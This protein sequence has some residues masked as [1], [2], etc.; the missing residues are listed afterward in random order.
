MATGANTTVYFIKEVTPGVTPDTPKWTPVGYKS[1]SLKREQPLINSERMRGDRMNAPSVN[2]VPKV[3]G[4]ISTEL[5]YGE[6]DQL[7]AAAF[8]LADWNSEKVKVGK[9]NQTFSILEKMDGVTGKKWRIYRGCVVNT[10]SWN[11]EAGAIIQAEYGFVGTDAEMLSDAPSG[12]TYNQSSQ[13]T[14]MM[15]LVGSV[16]VDDSPY[17]LVTSLSIN[18]DNGADIRPVVGSK[19][20]LPITLRNSTAT[21]NITLY[22]ENSDFAEKAQ[23]EERLKL[24]LIF[25]DGDDAE[26]GNRYKITATKVKPSDAWPTIEGAEDITMQAAVNFEPDSATGTHIEIERINSG[27]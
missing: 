15:G 19:K 1:T 2:G 26:N 18:I 6:Q 10:L 17:G 24:E 13:N 5:V 22:Y 20:S 25:S 23:T 27:A 7:I 14:P 16:K 11:I 3:A 8:G 4:S 21:G 12:S 9:V